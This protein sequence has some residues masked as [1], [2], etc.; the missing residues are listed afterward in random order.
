MDHF[1]LPG[2]E[3]TQ[4]RKR[5]ALTRNFM[6]YT[7]R[8][9]TDLIAFGISGIGEVDGAFVQNAK[10]LS[11]Y[12]RLLEEGK[13]PV[14]RGYVLDD[15]DRIRRF[16]ILSLMC[17]FEVD[18]TQ[19]HNRFG[20]D[21]DTYFAREIRKLEETIEPGFY[22]REDGKLTITPLGRIFIRNICMVF[23]RN[24]EEAATKPLYSRTI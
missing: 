22:A 23:D 12:Y 19:L 15:D 24:L 18:L 17:N 16:V 6:G 8:P 1:A 2:D 21:Y 11:D 14:D 13:L 10:K 4:A 20:I 3:L 7:V 5:G 9:G